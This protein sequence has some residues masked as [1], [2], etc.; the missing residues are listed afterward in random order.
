MIFRI[1]GQIIICGFAIFFINK[2]TVF[3]FAVKF[4]RVTQ[5]GLLTI[6]FC[7]Y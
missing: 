2:L 3:R 1:V 4:V 6:S 7:S 5:L